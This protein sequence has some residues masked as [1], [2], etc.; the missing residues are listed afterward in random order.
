MCYILEYVLDFR[1]CDDV[2]DIRIFA[3][4][5]K[6]GIRKLECVLD[7]R[8]CDTYSS[9]RLSAFIW[10]DDRSWNVCTCTIQ[11]VVLQ[12]VLGIRVYVLEYRY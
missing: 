9:F 3:L 1:V 7:I 2:L 8:I 10:R 6:A 5:I 4:H 11:C 12:Y